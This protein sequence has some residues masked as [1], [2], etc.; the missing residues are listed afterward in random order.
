M[1]ADRELEDVKMP[2]HT[3]AALQSILVQ[4]S[5]VAAMYNNGPSHP[6]IS[7]DMIESLRINAIRLIVGNSTI[8]PAHISA[9]MLIIRLASADLHIPSILFILK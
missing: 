8:Y 1:H 4:E 6:N 3:I 9:L 2:D 7:I 5:E